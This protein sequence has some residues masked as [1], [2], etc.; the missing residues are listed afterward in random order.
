[1]LQRRKKE[2]NPGKNP[3]RAICEADTDIRA[4]LG[5][6]GLIASTDVRAMFGRKG[7]LKVRNM[8]T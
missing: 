8:H 2:S 4:M 3:C 6:K 7:L 5:R 1:M